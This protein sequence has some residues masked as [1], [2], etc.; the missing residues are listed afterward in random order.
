MGKR[1]FV[2]GSVIAG[3]VLIPTIAYA[4][5]GL[6]APNGAVN[7]VR[8]TTLAAYHDGIEHYITAFEFSGLGGAKFGSIVPLPGEPRSVKR[9]GDWTLQRLLQ[10]VQPPIPAAFAG[11]ALASDAATSARVV[12]RTKVDSLDITVVEGGADGV[13]RW[14]TGEG[15]RLSPDAPEVLEFYAQ[16]SRFFM[17]VSFDAARAQR[18]GQVAGDSVPVHITIPTER[19]WVPLRILSLGRQPLEPVEADIFLLT[20][21]APALLPAPVGAGSAAG[22]PVARGLFVERSQRASATLTTDL[23]SDR[24]MGWMPE[25]PMWLTYLRLSAQARTLGY[26]LAIDPTGRGRPSW[27][28]AGFPRG[29]FGPARN[30]LIGPRVERVTETLTQTVPVAGPERVDRSGWFTT[31]ALLA[32]STALAIRRRIIRA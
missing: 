30:P 12:L 15:F 26:D 16:R 17:A 6:V 24:G 2:V 3:L 22:L 13:A 31:S 8:T 10:E 4:C 20:D 18:R 11:A 29:I 21:R 5:G 14:A 23:R 9:A 19:P 28:A 25:R 1:S 32:L 27:R 7:L